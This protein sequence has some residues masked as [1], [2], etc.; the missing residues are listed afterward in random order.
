[1]SYPSDDGLSGRIQDV[2]DSVGQVNSV[3]AGSDV[4]LEN[5]SDLKSVVD[6]LGDFLSGLRDGTFYS[7]VGSIVSFAGP[8]A[9]SGWF[10][11]AGQSWG[12]IHLGSGDPLYDMLQPVAAF[13]AGLPDLRGR[14]I[15]GV[16]SNTFTDINANPTRLYPVSAGAATLGSV[17][18]DSRLQA[19]THTGTTGNVNGTGATW[20]VGH[21]SSVSVAF[22]NNAR[23][24]SAG[25]I[26]IPLNSGANIH[27]LNSSVANHNLQHQHDF[28]TAGHNDSQG[29]SKNIQ[30]TVVLN[31][32][33]K[34]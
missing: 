2:L 27:T 9:P 20:D 13:S 24:A 4:L 28:T 23:G 31:Y 10:F 19:H 25:S 33:I 11:C 21:S 6:E 17:I 5:Y 30:P 26:L 3:G 29:S 8:V 12:S 15:A 1:M 18:G 34:S 32:I 7:P 22:A 14:V 16:D